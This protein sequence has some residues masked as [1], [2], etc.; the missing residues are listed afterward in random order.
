MDKIFFFKDKR[1]CSVSA[2]IYAVLAHPGNRIFP[3]DF[4]Y[5]TQ[6]RLCFLQVLV[7]KIYDTLHFYKRAGCVKAKMNLPIFSVS[8]P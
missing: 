8:V 7:L 5:V 2:A 6:P 1:M 3:V 4:R